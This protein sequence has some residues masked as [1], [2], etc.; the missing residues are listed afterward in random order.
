[1]T[2]WFAKKNQVC[3]GTSQVSV[4]TRVF[5]YNQGT[6]D[7]NTTLTMADLLGAD[8]IVIDDAPGSAPGVVGV[9]APNTPIF[10]PSHIGLLSLFKRPK[11]DDT[12]S[13]IFAN[14]SGNSVV[15]TI[16]NPVR[17]AIVLAGEVTQVF[18]RVINATMTS[19]TADVKLQTMS[20]GA[21]NSVLVPQQIQDLTLG[22]AA[23]VLAGQA[24]VSPQNVWQDR[25]LQITY[26]NT[27]ATL[28]ASTAA[29]GTS[30]KTRW[31]QTPAT[32]GTPA[33]A[34][35]WVSG[36]HNLLLAPGATQVGMPVV[37]PLAAGN[38]LTGEMLITNNTGGQLVIQL[39]MQDTDAVAAAAD[40]DVTVTYGTGIVTAGNAAVY[41][42]LTALVPD[43]VTL[44]LQYQF[45]LVGTA[46]TMW[47]GTL[48]NFIATD[49]AV[50]A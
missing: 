3:R 7:P 47:A 27:D 35:G 20:I 33:V 18:F 24:L 29:G 12:F 4:S 26:T 22:N 31:S 32:S 37:G 42:A 9:T 16:D 11:V 44:R 8:Q 5:L 38:Q 34:T 28:A 46:A 15:L 2:S 6:T 39:G 21:T 25:P 41:G 1:M 10:L 48:V 45:T 14:D 13:V 40:A 49:L 50:V 23:A 19:G 17:T 43:A 30:P 36:I